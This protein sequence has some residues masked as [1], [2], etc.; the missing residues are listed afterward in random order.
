MLNILVFK[1]GE[2]CFGIETIYVKSIKENLTLTDSGHCP[3]F[4][5]GVVAFEG[6]K[7]FV[8]DVSAKNAE[9]HCWVDFI[10]VSCE[11][12]ELVVPVDEVIEI[13]HIFGKDIMP[14]PAFAEKKISRNIFKGVVRIEDRLILMLDMDK[15]F[16]LISVQ[17]SANIN[18]KNKKAAKESMI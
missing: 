15:L 14:I 7:V 11:G 1:T 9:K 8:I 13:F 6:R 12:S 2:I 17:I 16:N 18:R 3:D 10:V 4:A 5:K